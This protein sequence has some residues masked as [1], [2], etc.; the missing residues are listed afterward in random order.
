M[1]IGYIAIENKIFG[2]NFGHLAPPSSKGVQFKRLSSQFIVVPVFGNMREREAEQS[3]IDFA[4]LIDLQ[5]LL[6][7]FVEF[8][9]VEELRSL[10]EAVPWRLAILARMATRS[11]LRSVIDVLS[12]ASRISYSSRRD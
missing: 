6:R 7:Y 5:G 10:R 12:E 1:S 8:F 3:Q 4:A 9:L 2:R 11:L